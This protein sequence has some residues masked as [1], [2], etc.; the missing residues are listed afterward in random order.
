MKGCVLFCFFFLLSMSVS[1]IHF[2]NYIIL[3]I[4]IGV[5]HLDIE[6]MA[7]F[8]GE[9]WCLTSFIVLDSDFHLLIQLF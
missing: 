8:F 6:V 5:A 3:Y 4:A 1:D 9:K 7:P 2:M